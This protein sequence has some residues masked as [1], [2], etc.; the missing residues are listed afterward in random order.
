MKKHLL[1]LCLIPLSIFPLFAQSTLQ[2]SVYFDTNKAE[3]KREGEVSL[4]E[5]AIFLNQHS[6]FQI[7]LTGNTDADGNDAFNRQLSERRIATVRQFLEQKG[8]NLAKITTLAFGKAQPI[9]DNATEAGKK[10]NRR[11]DIKVSFVE[12]DPSV[13][14]EKI[15]DW[16]SLYRELAIENQTFKVQTNKDTL[17]RGEKGTVLLIP[18]NAFAGIPEGAVIDFNLKEA[19]SFSDIIREN[20]NTMSG[21][22]ALQTGGMI[23]LE[24]RYKG[25]ELALQVPIKVQFNS[26]ESQLEGMQ[27]FTGER[28]EG[29]NEGRNDVE[30]N[31][32]PLSNRVVVKDTFSNPVTIFSVDDEIF[33]PFLV[34]NEKTKKV[35]TFNELC[36][37]SGCSPLL[38]MVNDTCNIRPNMPNRCDALGIYAYV[39]PA[40]REASVAQIHREAFDDIYRLYGVNDLATLKQQPAAK[41]DDL[42]VQRQF[43]VT[44]VETEAYLERLKKEDSLRLIE[45]GKDKALR[46]IEI[47]KE[48]V[49]DSIYRG[50]LNKNPL[51]VLDKLGWVNCDRFTKKDKVMQLSVLLP[52]SDNYNVKVVLKKTNQ[53]IGPTELGKNLSKFQ[54]GSNENV[55]VI[56]F[57]LE[58]GISYFA[59]KDLKMKDNQTFTPEFEAMT[60]L[61]IKKRLKVLD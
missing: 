34:L 27:L 32:I 23:Y 56:A 9:A 49:R 1:C 35:L 12:K 28:N 16:G 38:I 55:I 17:I 60:P 15:T 5:V 51:L 31:W 18:K 33:I 22:K 39:R 46:L 20:L 40:L 14:S 36:D 61:E 30:I 54:I 44:G 6:S 4:A 52:R 58:N 37:T 24:A 57:A 47:E 10:Q 19:Y 41:Y 53:I 48:R 13:F 59:I 42:M 26:K 50:K 7:Q 29:R 8:I 25:Q 2:R 43:I 45:M 11:V 3:L 21:D